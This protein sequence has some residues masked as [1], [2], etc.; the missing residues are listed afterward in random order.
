[1]RRHIRRIRSASRLAVRDDVSGGA[2]AN[3]VVSCKRVAKESRFG[4]GAVTLSVSAPIED[5]DGD[6]PPCQSGA[7]RA[8]LGDVS[9]ISVKENHGRLPGMKEPAVEAHAVARFERDIL[10]LYR[11]VRCVP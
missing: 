2:R 4:R 8:S 1:M 11:K 3:V 5:Q 6:S 10:R 7:N 9:R